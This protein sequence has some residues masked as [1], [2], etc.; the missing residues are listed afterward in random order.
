VWIT[1]GQV[2]REWFT[3]RLPPPPPSLSR[4][5]LCILY[6][7]DGSN[8][9]CPKRRLYIII[10]AIWLSKTLLYIIYY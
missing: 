8:Y 9:P 4:V 6:G 5:E 10:S 7:E 1:G 2:G 3:E